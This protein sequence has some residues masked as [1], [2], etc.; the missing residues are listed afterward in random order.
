MIKTRKI[1]INGENRLALSF[2]YDADIISKIKR[3]SESRWIATRRL[4]HLPYNR[5]SANELR[6]IFPDIELPADLVSCTIFKDSNSN[7]RLIISKKRL[8]VFSDFSDEEIDFL[9]SITYCRWSYTRKCFELPNY[10]NNLRKIRSFFAGRLHEIEWNQSEFAKEE[11]I[12]EFHKIIIKT[13]DYVD[14]LIK[15]MEKWLRY[16]RY[17]EST[18]QSYT[19]GVRIFLSFCSPKKPEEID[20]KDMI[21]FVN[22]YIVPNSYSYSFQNQVINGAK[23]FFREVMMTDLDV[24]K[25][26]RPRK[27]RKLPNVLSKLEVKRILGVLKNQKHRTILSLIY[28]CGLRRSE[29]LNLHPDDIDSSRLFLIIRN[30]KGKK[31]RLVPISENIL[32]ILREYYKV[33]RPSVWLFEGSTPGERYSEQSLQSVFKQ[34][35]KKAG[36]RKPITLHGLRHSYA[37]H[38]LESGVDLRYIQELLGHRNSKTTEIYTHVSK[39][40]L[41]NIPSP[42]DL[43]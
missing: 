32:D 30:S 14:P 8:Y 34:A 23:I 11:N 15:K 7:D 42:F 26:E 37:T 13:P 18:I 17:S 12:D 41:G 4:W 19:D 5:I 16:R 20:N 27:E 1:Q 31:D 39:K 35:I 40:N 24:E 25:F 22:E 33:Y 36:I 21:R 3:L 10:G 28:A 6:L 29:V 43:L 2:R 9:K 38:L